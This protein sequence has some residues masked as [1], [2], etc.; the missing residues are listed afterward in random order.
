MKVG[1]VGYGYVG[2][3]MFDFFKGHCDVG[4]YDTKFML[5]RTNPETNDVE[6]ITKDWHKAMREE[7]A[8]IVNE[9]ISLRSENLMT[10]EM[11]NECDVAVV[12]V[13]TPM[14][15]DN[16]CDTSIVD[17]TVAWL[18]TPLIIIKSTIT[19]GTTDALVNKYGKKG[20][21]FSP[22]YCGESSYWTPYKFHTDVKETPFFIFGGEPEFTTKCV[23]LYMRIAG[24]TKMYRQ[25]SALVAETAKYMENTFYAAKV[26]LCHEFKMVCDALNVDY[27]DAREVWL[28]DPRLN[29]MHTAVFDKTGPPF[30]G[31][32]FPKDVNAFVKA[33]QLKGY[34]PELLKEV[35]ASNQ[36]IGE[37]R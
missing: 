8:F 25:C 19:P 13:P 27:N 36:R 16:A 33:S 4:V 24:P 2:Q 30:G 23:D 31:K 34:S 12:C 14:D 9:D 17:E 7:Q 29:P 22:E 1:I 11:I 15:D 5:C 32:C 21:I 20:I 28:L 3:A 10:K 26:V 6:S 35:L 18:E 37:L